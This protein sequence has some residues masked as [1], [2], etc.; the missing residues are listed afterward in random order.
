MINYCLSI[1]L[2]EEY[3]NTEKQELFLNIEK[4]NCMVMSNSKKK[5]GY[6]NRDE[7]EVYRNTYVGT[8]K[9]QWKLG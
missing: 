5:D 6:Y 7:I 9:Q 4:T 8:S 3:H 2:K 1:Q